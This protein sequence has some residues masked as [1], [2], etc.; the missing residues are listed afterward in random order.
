MSTGYPKT[1]INILSATTDVSN[2]EQKILFIGQKTASG[3]ATSSTLITDIQNDKS[4]DTLFGSNS[5]L[6]GMIRVA[7]SI[8][9]VNRIDAIALDDDGG[10]TAATATIDLTG[11]ATASGTII[12]DIISSKDYRFSLPVSSTDTGTALASSLVSL[13]NA[14]VNIPVT[15]S[16]STTTVTLTADNGGTE[17]NNFAL[18]YSG[19]VSGIVT[20][21]TG[22]TGGATDPS[23]TGITD[24]IGNTR[25]QAIVSPYAYGTTYL[26]DLLDS[27]FNVTNNI[28]DGVAFVTQTDSVSNIKTFAN[29]QNSNSLVIFSH[30][31]ADNDN[32]K[33]SIYVEA[34]Y[35]ISS[36][37]A[38]VR[39]FRLTDGT[40]ISD[41][42]TTTSALDTFG[43]VATASLP[44]FNTPFTQLIPCDSS[45]SLTDTEIEELTESGASV[46]QNNVTNTDVIFGQMVTTYKT[47][48]AGNDDIS[49]KYL[50]YVD[51]SSNAREYQFNNIKKDFSQSRL[52]DNGNSLVPY[53]SI[54][55]SDLIESAFVGYYAT[56]SSDSYVLTRAGDI[57]TK[58]YKDNLSITIDL[59]TG[60]ATVLQKVPIVTQL[61]NIVSTFQLQFNI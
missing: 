32:L 35:N 46:F 38:A 20:T 59:S 10:A 53:R 39:S 52:T 15:A 45:L 14:N 34:P 50:N 49:F 16:S 60:T 25:Y 21:L 47:D 58:F 17:A 4:W 42:V 11:T 33:G 1:S 41:F 19:S 18:A 12:F 61:R 29:T 23:T 5:M 37:F 26:T 24:L 56:L 28:L 7:R 31:S 22:F 44:Y 27:R 8:N 9:T 6:A 55:N 36:Y 48:S 3:T 2:S 43:G 54:S 40:D 57:S 30:I 13:I 51:T